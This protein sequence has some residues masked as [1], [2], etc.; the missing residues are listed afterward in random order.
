MI[1]QAA[2]F[3]IVNFDALRSLDMSTTRGQNLIGQV[4]GSCI[5]E[6]LLGYGGSSAVFLAQNRS[7]NEQVA[8]KVFLQRSTMDKQAQKNFYQR[9][10][11]EAE[12]TIELDHPNILSIY[13]YGEY[14]GLPYIVMPYISGGT[15][16]EYVARFGPL[17]LNS[18]QQYLAQIASALDYA[19]ENGRVHCDVKPAN[20]LLDNWGQVLLSDFGI[21]HLMRTDGKSTDPSMKSSDILMGTPDFISPEQALGETLDG[22]SDIYSL[23][24]TLF[25]L[26]AGRPPFQADSSIT[27]A[28]MH[29]HDTPPS[30]STMRN[31]ITPQIDRVIAKALAKWP[32]ERYE[33]AGK[34]SAAFAEAVANA[35]TYVLSD[36]EAKR[37]AIIFS[38]ASKRAITPL[39][40]IAQNT[41]ALKGSKKIWRI[42]LPLLVLVALISGSLLSINVVNKLKTAPTHVQPTPASSQ[43]DYLLNDDKWPDGQVNS[44]YFFKNGQYH[45]KNS[46]KQK[47]N[48]ALYD[49]GNA[50]SQFKNFR[51]TVT[52]TE[53]QGVHNDGDYCGIVL[54][55]TAN[56]RHYYLFEITPSGEYHQ[57]LF[58]RFDG[59]YQTL[60]KTSYVPSLL[61]NLG[62]SN[63][64]TIEV[65]DNTFTFSVN[66][67]PLGKVTDTS[68]PLSS[69]GAIGLSAD[70]SGT[71]I[72]FSQLHIDNL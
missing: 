5:L 19:H 66:Q 41:S 17:S 39:I 9:F 72:A 53:I 23:A 3:F 15:L 33:T 27:L 40:P 67:L 30:L 16:S 37:K 71:E 25:F 48:I 7:T 36:S 68:K 50:S 64:I 45:I 46:P 2:L 24:V 44:T 4:I 31:D 62:Q 60:L 10:L 70:G 18:A 32:E 42:A 28:L 12:A 6:R 35:D 69:A 11:R 43:T 51:M 52:T 59:K 1:S 38:G 13:S 47:F 49:F 65:K 63:V 22:R 29:V 56:E 54:R 26:L 58:W 55:S 20:L 57:Y 34:F 61:P 14:N 8:V 21:V